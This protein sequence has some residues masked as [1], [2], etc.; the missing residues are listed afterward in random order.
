MILRYLFGRER[1]LIILK[2]FVHALTI[3]FGEPKS[4][5]T[6]GIHYHVFVLGCM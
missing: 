5:K 3:Y 6:S 2:V 4:R 1:M